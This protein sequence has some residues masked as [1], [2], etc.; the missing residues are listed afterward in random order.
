VVG[1][2]HHGLGIMAATS[3]TVRAELASEPDVERVVFRCFS[4]PDREVY[5]STW[6]RVVGDGSARS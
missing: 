3:S 1:R 2:K 6:A 4:A 5:A